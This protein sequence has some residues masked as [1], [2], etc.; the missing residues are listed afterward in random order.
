MKYYKVK[1]TNVH[2][3]RSVWVLV[4]AESQATGLAIAEKRCNKTRSIYVL[5]GE[6]VEVSQS[7]YEQIMNNSLSES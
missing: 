7:E 5:T 2:N 1:L 3:A 6:I 4:R